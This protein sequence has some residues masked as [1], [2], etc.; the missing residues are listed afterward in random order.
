[1]EAAIAPP[2]YKTGLSSA[3]FT[4]SRKD[5]CL[6]IGDD[7][8][9]GETD[10][11]FTVDGLGVN[12][13]D[14]VD[15][16]LDSKP[17]GSARPFE[18]ANSILSRYEAIERTQQNQSKGTGFVSFRQKASSERPPRALLPKHLQP[19]IPSGSF[20]KKTTNIEEKKSS[21]YQAEAHR[22]RAELA[23]AKAQKEAQQQAVKAKNARAPPPPPPPVLSFGKRK[24]HSRK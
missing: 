16:P 12:H 5:K 24:H 7:D 23:Q 9:E 22:L 19:A 3:V 8:A 1:M 4:G 20:V 14:P 6:L 21:D 2:S 17:S 10:V 18:S 13:Y 15:N 11:D